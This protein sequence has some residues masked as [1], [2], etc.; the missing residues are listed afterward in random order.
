MLEMVAMLS[1]VILSLLVVPVGY[2]S[3]LPIQVLNKSTGGSSTSTSTGVSLYIEN[4]HNTLLNSKSGILPD[5]KTSYAPRIMLASDRRVRE[6]DDRN[7][8]ILYMM[9]LDLPRDFL[10][11]IRKKCYPLWYRLVLVKIGHSQDW[12]HFLEK[13][14][15]LQVYIP[16]CR[17][18]YI[19]IEHH[20]LPSK[21]A[22]QAMHYVFMAYHVNGEW[23]YMNG[24]SKMYL[25]SKFPGSN[26]YLG[27]TTRP[28]RGS[29]W[30]HEEG[31][32]HV[33]LA[34]FDW[35]TRVLPTCRLG[36]FD[37]IRGI[38]DDP[39][40]PVEHKDIA[41]DMLLT[42]TGSTIDIR[43][44]MSKY[45]YAQVFANIT[46][47]AIPSLSIRADELALQQDWHPYWKVGEWYALDYPEDWYQ[48]GNATYSLVIH[49]NIE[50]LHDIWYRTLEQTNIYRHDLEMWQNMGLVSDA[51]IVYN[52]LCGLVDV[53]TGMPH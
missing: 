25:M 3:D 34:K 14:K 6:S 19:A 10:E 8:S 43:H 2:T 45:T 5:R 30:T 26:I 44:R 7:K 48:V 24:M 31:Q 41:E 40:E 11:K 18:K 47:H 38:L 42:K 9:W 50:F 13:M 16:F 32:G 49:P 36:A 52:H 1:I 53:V 23:Y 33:Y 27:Y 22:E 15:I 17:L 51:D 20:H 21:P 46:Y 12:D 29:Y 28:G 4:A 37:T 35:D 39:T